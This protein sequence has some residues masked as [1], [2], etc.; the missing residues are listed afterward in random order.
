MKI[1]FSLLL[2]FFFISYIGASQDKIITTQNDT[3]NCKI[4]KITK[5][6]IYFD[7]NTKNVKSSGEVPVSEVS[8]YIIEPKSSENQEVIQK[9]F[10]PYQ[11]LRLALGGGFGYLFASSKEAEQELVDQGFSKKQ[12]QSFFNG[13]RL[14]YLGNADLTYFISPNYGIGAKYK[15]FETSN[16]QE[17][18]LDPQDGVNLI[19]GNLG[20]KI[21]VN[22]FGATFHSQQW[23]AKQQKLKLNSTYALGL[24]TYRNEMDVVTNCLLLT[25][26]SFGMDINVGI[27][28]FISK[29]ISL[30][31]DLS[32]FYSSIHKFKVDDG[33]NSTT[34]KLDK[35]NYENI[36]RI[37]LS[38]GIK[39]Y[40]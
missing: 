34:M 14:G 27:E 8:H 13:L 2:L 15:F 12:S 18:F 29:N 35:D 36:S 11:H 7:L 33:T 24:A 23:I 19:Y 3:I 37:D 6:S 22:F 38:F 40:R 20:E 28:Y 30:G 32:G 25:G 10:V 17:G 1:S 26:K 39:I 31:I 16:S 21:Y 5:K 9:E 4:K